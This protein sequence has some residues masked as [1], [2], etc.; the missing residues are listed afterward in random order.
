[1]PY[2]LTYFQ[3][4]YQG[5]NHS[6]WKCRSSRRNIVSQIEELIRSPTTLQ[7]VASHLIK[8][9]ADTPLSTVGHKRS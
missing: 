5:S 3:Q 7:G 8:N 6:V 2:A 9:H 1:M 4:I